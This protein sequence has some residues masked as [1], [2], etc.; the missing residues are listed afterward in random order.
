MANY[1]HRHLIL[2]SIC[3]L[4][5]HNN[6]KCHSEEIKNKKSEHLHDLIITLEACENI[7]KITG[8]VCKKKAVFKETVQVYEKVNP[9]QIKH[10]TFETERSSITSFKRR[11]NMNSLPFSKTLKNRFYV[12]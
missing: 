8:K 5:S 2:L 7:F 3:S 4:T 6:N 11:D 12:F 1:M 9:N 10:S